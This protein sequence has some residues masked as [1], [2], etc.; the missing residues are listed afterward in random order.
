MIRRG[1]GAALSGT[2]TLVQNRQLFWFTILAGLVLV[3]NTIGQAALVSIGRTVQPDII[4]SYALDFFLEFA[5]LLCFVFIL[6]GL[7]LS[8]PSGKK[9]SVSFAEGLAGAKKYAKAL[10]LWSFVL[11]IVGM[12]LV[13][14]WFY[15]PVCQVSSCSWINF[16]GPYNFSGILEQFPFNLTMDPY[17]FTE[18]PGYGGRSILLL[19]Y[20]MGF[21]EAL[22]Y[23][24]INLLLFI[25][26]PFVVPFI[27][28]EQKTIREA[29]AGS[30]ATM[31]KIWVETASCAVFL[32]VVIAGVFL[33]YLLV[34]AAHGQYNDP[35]MA[36]PPGM[37]SARPTDAWI[38]L[39]LIYDLALFSVAFIVATVAGI[40]A[41]DLYRFARTGC[42]AGS[43]EP[44][45]VA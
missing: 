42:T 44:E 41:L 35:W 34:Q 40:A 33:A 21:M 37:I 31:K 30:F 38:A 14:L 20:P 19:L 2:K 8:I 3:G 39:G 13:R 17:L 24:A 28:L 25:V 27:V 26:T 18:L 32:G 45:P 5:T 12:L 6:A 10:F 15:Y 23:S 43:A 29:V 11:A 22:T 9:R 16:F 36:W 7:V 1:L 4:V